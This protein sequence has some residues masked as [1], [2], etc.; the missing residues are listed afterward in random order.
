MMLDLKITNSATHLAPGR[1]GAEKTQL[2]YD[3][4]IVLVVVLVLENRGS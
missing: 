1:Y 3:F 2:G 4:V